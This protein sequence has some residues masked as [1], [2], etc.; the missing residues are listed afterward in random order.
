MQ[1]GV[2]VIPKSSKAERLAENLDVHSFELAPAEMD[3]LAGIDK[4]KRFNDPGVF[5]EGMGAFVPI[6]D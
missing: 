4:H 3:E 1:R 6:F 5:C 2:A